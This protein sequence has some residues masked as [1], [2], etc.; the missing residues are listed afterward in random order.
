VT[1]RSCLKDKAQ[2]KYEKAVAD[3]LDELI[4]TADV[5]VIFIPQV[6]ATKGDDDRLVGR[7]V[8]SLMHR[9]YATT[10]IHDTPDHHRIKAIY[11]NLDILLG[12]RFHSVIFSLTSYVPV[13]AIEYEHK[14]SGIMRD[15]QLEDWVIKIEDVSAQNLGEALQNLVNERASYRAHLQKQLPP[16]I[17]K[18]RQTIAMVK[19]ALSSRYTDFQNDA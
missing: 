10:L 8:Q 7:R 12:T 5:Y 3:A 16:Y 13:L 11:D 9:K 1:V 17:Q 18:T 2:A 6:T 15:L 4:K 14:T 19:S